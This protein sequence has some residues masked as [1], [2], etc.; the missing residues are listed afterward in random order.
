[1]Y[2]YCLTVSLNVNVVDCLIAYRC[3]YVPMRLTEDERRMLQ[4][5]ENALEVCEYT[6]RF[7]FL[8]T[9]CM[10]VCMYVCFMI[11]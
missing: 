5:L 11:Y 9:V 2:E 6:V 1:M 10:Y 3:K 7:L 4:V 8:C